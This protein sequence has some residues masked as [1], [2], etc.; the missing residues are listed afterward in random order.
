MEKKSQKNRVI[1][2]VLLMSLRIFPMLLS[3]TCTK[4]AR[5]ETTNLSSRPPASVLAPP[6]NYGQVPL[7]FE[8]NHG[9]ANEPV[10]YLARGTN[11]TLYLTPTEAALEIRNAAQQTALVKMKLVGA[12][13]SPVL[14]GQGK[15]PGKSNYFAGKD[16]TQWKRNIPTYR[17]V[18]YE[19]VYDGID[20]V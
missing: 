3:P 8:A 20:L 1:T 13:A 12:N 5:Y 19:Q 15:L 6:S 7:S 18:K 16:T 11:A 4:G 10:Q 17:Q 9:Q 14:R 2:N